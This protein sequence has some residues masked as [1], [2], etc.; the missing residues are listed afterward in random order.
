M[1]QCTQCGKA[2]KGRCDKIFCDKHCRNEHHN[3]VNRKN[4]VERDV[5]RILR[6]NRQILAALKKNELTK[7]PKM[8]LFRAGF[9]FEFYTHS[10]VNSNGVT[11]FFCYDLGYLPTENNYFALVV[12][13]DYDG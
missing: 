4:N 5:N 3:R 13:N 8:E 7:H 12:Q 2:L 9:N 10:T 11:C 6:K 1:I